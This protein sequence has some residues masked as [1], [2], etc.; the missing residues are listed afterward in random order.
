MFQIDD[1]GTISFTQVVQS[2]WNFS[3]NHTEVCSKSIIISD[4]E[5]NNKNQHK[6]LSFS[7]KS[8]LAE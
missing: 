5:F 7:D 1:T 8:E 3:N 4:I 6:V 2:T